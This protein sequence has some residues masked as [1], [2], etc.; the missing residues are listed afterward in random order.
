MINNTKEAVH[1]LGNYITSTR[2]LEDAKKDLVKENKVRL[3]YDKQAITNH[4]LSMGNFSL[5]Y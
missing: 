1:S 3:E 2:A 4:T 5:I